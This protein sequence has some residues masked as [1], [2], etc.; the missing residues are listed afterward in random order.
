MNTQDMDVIKDPEL[1]H[2]FRLVRHKMAQQAANAGGGHAGGIILL[3]QLGMY[4]CP[5]FIIAFLIAVFFRDWR[6]STEIAM[7]ASL[8]G[9]PIHFIRTFRLDSAFEKDRARHCAICEK[10]LQF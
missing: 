7:L 4:C 2:S 9:V 3:V 1:E 6:S 5:I 8:I 10:Y